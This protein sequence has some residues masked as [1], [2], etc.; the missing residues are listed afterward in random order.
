MLQEITRTAPTVIEVLSKERPDRA[1]RKV[2]NR[3]CA[4]QKDTK[5][6]RPQSDVE[7]G[8]FV[9]G[10]RFV[11]TPDCFIGC[12]SYERMVAMVD[13]ATRG[14]V[15]VRGATIAEYRILRGGRGLL[16]AR[17]ALRAHADDHGIR[18][19]F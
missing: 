10:K 19:C 15:A 8:I 16:K 11:I 14:R 17:V 9:P 18:P 5:P 12:N 2:D 7:F 1:T 3:W 6:I 13:E 4:C